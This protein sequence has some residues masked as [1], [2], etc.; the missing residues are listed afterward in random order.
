[1][2]NSFLFHSPLSISLS[3]N[4]P[5]HKTP[6]ILLSLFIASIFNNF[7]SFL[8]FLPIT[9][10]SC[11]QNNSTLTV[12]LL[13]FHCSYLN[14]FSF[15]TSDTLPLSFSFSF[16]SLPFLHLHFHFIL[17]FVLLHNLFPSFTHTRCSSF[18]CVF[19]PGYD[20]QA[21]CDTVSCLCS[22]IIVGVSPSFCGSFMSVPSL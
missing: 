4:P 9:T 19:I 11:F 15:P 16:H 22:L 20:T 1:M 18:C 7:S 5:F 2:S 10:L 17:S 3:F 14:P 8:F 12:S 6:F 13:S 21:L